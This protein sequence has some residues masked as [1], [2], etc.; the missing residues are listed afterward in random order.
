MLVNY[1]DGFEVD[2]WATDGLLPSATES[3]ILDFRPPP[4]GMNVSIYMNVTCHIVTD[5]QRS[6]IQKATHVNAM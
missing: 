6:M 5:A 4:S 2:P 1:V 3:T